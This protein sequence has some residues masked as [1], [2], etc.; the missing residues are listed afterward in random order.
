VKKVLII[1]DE[2]DSL[3]PV[4]ML[5]KTYAFNVRSLSD[6]KEIFD[7]V[8]EYKPDVIVLDINLSGYD[9]R[10]IAMLLK[11]NPVTDATKIILYSGYFDNLEEFPLYHADDFIAKPFKMRDLVNKINTH[12]NQASV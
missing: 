1:D 8:R 3:V 11:E 5:L 10:S 2:I 7:V 9:G 12:L 4:M 6:P